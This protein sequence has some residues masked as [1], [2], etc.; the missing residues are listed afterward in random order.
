MA[1]STLAQQRLDAAA[2]LARK[3][4]YDES[5][6]LYRQIISDGVGDVD[7][8]FGLGVVQFLR[9]DLNG[10]EYEFRNCLQ[11]NPKHDEALYYIGLIF[12]RR[13]EPDQAPYY[14]QKA[15]QA[16]P[17]NLAAKKKLSAEVER[18]KTKLIGEDRS[19]SHPLASSKSG[20]SEPASQLGL[21]G[22]LRA[23]NSPLSRQTL[24]LIDSLRMEIRPRKSAYLGSFL[25]RAGCLLLGLLILEFAI[26]YFG[27]AGA[28]RASVFPLSGVA[29]IL[30]VALVCLTGLPLL[31]LFLRVRTTEYALSEGQLVVSSG[32]LR[33]ST[34]YFQ[35]YHVLPDIGV[36]Q[37]FLNR[38]THDGQLVLPMDKET[39]ELN[40]LARID[41]L[42]RIADRLRN[43]IIL[44]RSNPNLKGI[45]R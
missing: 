26:A 36:E 41:E 20:M 8:H 33:R 2:D 14:Y 5:E 11:I 29:T 10:A 12:E 35:L 4:A 19:E 1:N 24:E 28:R 34:N 16:N 30:V 3:G 15:L 32:V 37:T 40:G 45:I 13:G 9:R 44:L 42:K 23:D 18:S 25:M 31:L 39:I 43:L 27:L 7:A 22:L 6:V 21:T 38:L 17:A